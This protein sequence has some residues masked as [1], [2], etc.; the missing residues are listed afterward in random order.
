MESAPMSADG[1]SNLLLKPHH[2][3]QELDF[4]LVGVIRIEDSD[5]RVTELVIED[6]VTVI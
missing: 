5:G 4:G 6:S 2:W 1:S 3:L